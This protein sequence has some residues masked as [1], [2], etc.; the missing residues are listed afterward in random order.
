MVENK[1]N[2]NE[3]IILNVKQILRGP[4]KWETSISMIKI[5]QWLSNYWVFLVSN[6]YMWNFGKWTRQWVSQIKIV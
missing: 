3:F 1:S 4:L 5:S 2:F 6:I